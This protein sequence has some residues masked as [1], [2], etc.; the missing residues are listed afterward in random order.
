MSVISDLCRDVPLPRFIPVRQEF[1]RTRITEEELESVIAGQLQKPGVGDTI[2]PGMRIAIT[3]GSRGICNIDRITRILVEALKQ[4][5]ALPFIVPAMGSHAGATAEGQ[6]A[7]LGRFGIS[8]STMGCP[9]QSSM[10]TVVMGRTPDGH[11]VRIDRYAAEA[12]GI[13]PI[14]RIKPHTSFRGPYESGLVKML[15]IGLGKQAGADSCHDGGFGEMAERLPVF[16]R[17]ILDH[18][19][20]LFGVA[21]IENAYDQT[22]RIE[23]VPS[24]TILD[25]EPDLLVE[26]KAAMP[27]ILFD[28]LD[29]L[30]VDRIGK[31]ISGDGMDPNITGTFMTPFASGGIESKRVT[32]LDL[33]PETGGA[34][35]GMGMADTAT[36]RLFDKIDFEETYPNA[37][38]CTVLEFAKI[39]LILNSDREAI[40]CALRTA[41]GADRNAARMVR[42]ADTLHLEHILISEALL[43]QAQSME[44]VTI[45]GEAKEL[46][47]DKGRKSPVK[48]VAASLRKERIHALRLSVRHPV[49]HLL[50]RGRDRSPC[51]PAGARQRGRADPAVPVAAYR[52]GPA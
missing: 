7:Y 37:I 16:A 47:F 49:H 12:D 14:G 32:V 48:S 4:R 46:P 33:T 50:Y 40:Q 39:P 27:R 45:L 44:N 18:A 13:I 36:R 42:I 30:I 41:V 8:E 29:V 2:R 5:G 15:V 19:P 38:T 6:A 20:V 23:A 51:L 9:V 34:A 3:S 28:D 26:A 31:N 10:E 24:G 43:E 17:I 22:R 25:R 21:L 52:R 11:E 1:L 35:L